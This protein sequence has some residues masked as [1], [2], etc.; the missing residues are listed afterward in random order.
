MR[1]QRECFAERELV[2]GC[3]AGMDT[4]SARSDRD[5]VGR[6]GYTL[7]TLLSNFTFSRVLFSLSELA[8]SLSGLALFS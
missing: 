8:S 5:F 1:A 4:L 7:S 6:V 3:L 2:I